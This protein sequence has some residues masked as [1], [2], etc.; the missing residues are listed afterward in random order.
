MIH[1]LG[2]QKPELLPGFVVKLQAFANQMNSFLRGNSSG[3]SS[4]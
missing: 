4:V 3:D 1:T 2:R